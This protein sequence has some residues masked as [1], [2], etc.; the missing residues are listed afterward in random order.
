ME[1]EIIFP[2]ISLD[3]PVFAAVLKPY[4][5]GRA[6]EPADGVAFLSLAGIIR[7]IGACDKLPLCLRACNSGSGNG[8]KRSR[9]EKRHTVQ[10]SR[11]A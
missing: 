2:H 7:D 10:N 8:G 3:C 4:H 9:S 6:G 11:I 5:Y 1:P